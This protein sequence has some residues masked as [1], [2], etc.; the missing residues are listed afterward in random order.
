L[1]CLLNFF[2]FFFSSLFSASSFFDYF[3]L[4]L[5]FHLLSSFFF[6]FFYIRNP[7]RNQRRK[8]EIVREGESLREIEKPRERDSETDREEENPGE[9][10]PT[11]THVRG[12]APIVDWKP[13]F[14]RVDCGLTASSS[15][16]GVVKPERPIKI[17]ENPRDPKN[18]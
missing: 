12:S 11:Q 3:F 6:F 18:P 8:G 14:R 17:E 15:R 4:S 1:S 10:R 16:A 5:F 7:W 9:T 13:D 2:F